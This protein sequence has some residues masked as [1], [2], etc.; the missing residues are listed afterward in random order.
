MV[1]RDR[2]AA[3]C[4]PSA[5]RRDHQ[6]HANPVSVRPEDTSHW[7]WHCVEIIHRRILWVWSPVDR[8]ALRRS[9]RS[10]HSTRSPPAERW[11][12][13]G[14]AWP[15]GRHHIATT[16]G[17]DVPET[18]RDLGETITSHCRPEAWFGHVSD[19]NPLALRHTL[20]ARCEIRS[21][22]SR[23]TTTCGRRVRYGIHI[24]G[25]RH[26]GGQ[27]ESWTRARLIPVK[28]IGSDKEAEE[29]AT[30]ALLAVLSVVRP[31]SVDLF[32][33]LGASKAGRAQVECFTEVILDLQGK[34]VRPDGLVRV[35]YG[36]GDP[37]TA[38]IEVKTGTSTLEAE[39]LINYIKVA[40]QEKFDAVVT[41]SNE[42]APAPG[43]HPV[44]AAVPRANSN[45][46][47]HHISWT[48]LVTTAVR[49]HEHIGIED[50]EQ[51]WLLEELIRYLQ[52]T[53]SGALSFSDMGGSWVAVRNSA[54]DG[55]L[56]RTD[57][58]VTDIAH[59]WDQ[60]LRYI[61]L[62][63][64]AQIGQDVQQQLSTAHR[65]DP[66]ARTDA[67][68]RGMADTSCVQGTLRI[69]NTTGDLD[70]AVDLRARQI[71]CMTTLKAPEDKGA[72]GR[73]GWLTRQLK[74]GP[75]DLSIEARPHRARLGVSATLITA[76]EDWTALVDEQKREP[77]TFVL[78]Q[79][80]PMGAGR[81]AVKGKG[82]SSF[83]ESVEHA[84]TDYYDQ[85]LSRL[86][87]WQPKASPRQAVPEPA[88]VQTFE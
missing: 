3:R 10:G 74:D 62:T 82:H 42:I 29:R 67:L 38:L 71:C 30:S 5:A 25:R 72:R 48:Q 36:K 61:A 4:P 12:G 16:D 47:L 85:V 76:T 14:E 11:R 63:M 83:I 87:A 51:R 23:P 33:A 32:G 70:I 39:Q 49:L 34:K 44:G 31:L 43:L 40:R 24:R 53:S 28:G 54:K 81:S 17:S 86:T 2:E 55:T 88:D 65:T 77:A 46:A 22:R 80:Y 26:V 19:M 69:P 75:S 64:G 52:H 56:S 50:A 9:G 27:V 73:V 41:I 15:K 68:V 7:K 84:I 1:V 59:R 21:I 45:V 35:T 13:L 79:R 6:S 78:A 20:T 8:A 60:L 66:K 37:W 18:L 57:S 58:G